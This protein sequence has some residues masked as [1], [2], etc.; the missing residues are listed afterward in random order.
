MY[1]K[2]TNRPKRWGKALKTYEQWEFFYRASHFAN[3]QI[4]VAIHATPTGTSLG[5]TTWLLFSFRIEHFRSCPAFVLQDLIDCAPVVVTGKAR[6][7]AGFFVRE[8]RLLTI[9][10]V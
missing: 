10:S 6:S 4:A 1:S 3:L 2:T 7:P 5:D 9:P 8:Q